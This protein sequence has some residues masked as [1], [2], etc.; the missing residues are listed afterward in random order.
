MIPASFDYVRAGSADEA[1]VLG[2]ARQESEFIWRAAS[3][4]GRISWR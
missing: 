2:V 1:S 4:A 3:G